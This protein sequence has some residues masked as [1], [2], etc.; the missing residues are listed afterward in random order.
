MEEVEADAPEAE[1]EEYDPYA[2]LSPEEREAREKEEYIWRFR[3]LK[4]QYG[5]TPNVHIEDYNEHSDLPTMKRTYERTIREL[6]LDDAVET[7]RA[8]LVGGWMFL[9]YACTQWMEIDLE[10]FTLQQGRMMYKYDRMLIEL[11]EKSY[12]KWGMNLPV[13]VRLIGLILFQ[14]AMFFLGKVLG[15]KYGDGF[16]EMFRGFTGQPPPPAKK[17]SKAASATKDAR[18]VEIEDDEVEQPIPAKKMKGPSIKADDIRK[19][20]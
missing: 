6:Y 12:T 3:I 4:K 7:Y 1:E 18:V 15:D 10:G 2:G 13:E 9:E 8:Y 19:K 11:G 17:G 14:A 5:R 16:A 20:T